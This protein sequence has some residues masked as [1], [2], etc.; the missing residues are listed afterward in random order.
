MWKGAARNSH[1]TVMITVGTGIGGGI[2]ANEQILSGHNFTAGE[3]GYLPIGNADWQSLASAS[4]LVHMY[5]E[6]SGLKKQTGK[7]FLK[8]WIKSNPVALKVLKTYVNH[9]SQRVSNHFLCLKSRK[10]NFRRRHF[11]AIRCF[12]ATVENVLQHAIQDQRFY[13]EKL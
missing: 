1:S 7:T 12:V 10:D 3:I 5:E 11:C 13:R 8:Q 2:F 6:A 9:L 4:A